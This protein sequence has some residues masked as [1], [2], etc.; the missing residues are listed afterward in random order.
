VKAAWYERTGPA[1]EVLTAG[2]MPDPQPG[3]GEVRVRVH[4][5]GVNPADVKR[6]AGWA[7]LQMDFPRQI[8]HDDGAGVIESVGD[9]VDG[10]L[11]GRRVWLFDTRVNRSGGTAAELVCVPARNVEPL[12]PGL[13]FAEGASLSTPG[14]TAHRCLFSDGPIDGATVLVAGAAGAVGH[15]AVQQAKLAGA[16]VVG[17]VGRPENVAVA[18]S[19]GCDLVLDYKRDDVA[20]AV[21]DFTAG[22]GVD[23][24]VEVDF[25]ANVEIDARVCATNAT[26]AVY[27]TDTNHKPVV[28][29]WRFLNASVNLRFVLLYNLPYAEHR[30]AADDLNRWTNAGQLDLHVGL[31]VP[32]ADV[33]GAHKAIEQ[34]RG[35]GNVV[36]DIVDKPV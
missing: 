2:A 11:V 3:L 7:R 8:P 13:S 21:L 17:T 19:A 16:R 9:G 32:L 14:R 22:R 23:R 33:A 28:P 35:A 36:V 25:A 12:A 31:R 30:L 5:S 18:R 34:G 20:K 1:D 26:V 6:R 4:C 27:A 15:Q 24:I 10:G 29:A